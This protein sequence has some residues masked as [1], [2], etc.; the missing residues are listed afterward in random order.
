[1]ERFQERFPELWTSD[2]DAGRLIH[3]ECED[4]LV[5]GRCSSY[6]PLELASTGLSRQSADGLVVWEPTKMR[7][8][9]LEETVKDGMLVVTVLKGAPLEEARKKLH[10]TD[11]RRK[12][13]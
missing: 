9:V 11:H 1:L 3:A 6:A 8:Y 4:A 7:G 2:E 10:Q 5:S 12:R 13:Q